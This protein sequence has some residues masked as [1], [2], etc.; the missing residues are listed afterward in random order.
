VY[1]TAGITDTIVEA[2]RREW[3]KGQHG[4][5]ENQADG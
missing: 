5:G 1:G 2:V 3:Q 4:D